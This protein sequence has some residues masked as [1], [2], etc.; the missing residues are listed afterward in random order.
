MNK[1]EKEIVRFALFALSVQYSAG[2]FE[3]L[4]EL[5]EAEDDKVEVACGEF[6]EIPDEIELYQVAHYVDKEVVP[7]RR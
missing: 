2:N 4:M 1:R 6:V 7:C 5:L 3:K